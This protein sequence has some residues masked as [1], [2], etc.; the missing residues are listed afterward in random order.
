MRRSLIISRQ[1]GDLPTR[2][3]YAK[4]APA[5]F[6]LSPVEILLATDEEL[7]GLVGLK[8][9]APYRG[10]RN[11][12]AAGRGMNERVRQLKQ[13]LQQ[14]QWGEEL[15]AAEAAAQRVA[16]KGWQKKAPTNHARVGDAPPVKKRKGKSERMRA[17]KGVNAAA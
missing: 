15:D 9:L 2:F 11:Y 4:S 5:D 17:M 8:H 3:K 1:I 10:S 16:D 12:G 7:N 14:R 13:K 6:G